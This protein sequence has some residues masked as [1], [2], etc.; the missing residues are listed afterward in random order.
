MPPGGGIHSI[1]YVGGFQVDLDHLGTGE[2]G[3]R[4]DAAPSAS[5]WEAGIIAD[6]TAWLSDIGPESVGCITIGGR[7]QMNVNSDP[8]RVSNKRRRCRLLGG[9]RRSLDA[10]R[11]RGARSQPCTGPQF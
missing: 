11:A 1:G 10:P 7:L 2:I 3:I 9:E 4:Q 6:I 5:A 8:A